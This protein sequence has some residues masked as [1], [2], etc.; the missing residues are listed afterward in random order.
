MRR[1]VVVAVAVLAGCSGGDAPDPP[2]DA[3][4][5]VAFSV[6]Q[7]RADENTPFANLRVINLDPDRSVEVTAIGLDWPG[8][9]EP[10]TRPE[11]ATVMAGQTLD[12]RMRLP[13]PVCDPSEPRPATAVAEIDGVRV[14]GPLQAAGRSLLRSLWSRS[15]TARAVAAVA[16]IRLGG[17]WHPVDGGAEPAYAGT[18]VVQRTPGSTARLVVVGVTGSIL[19][20]A[21]A[22]TP[23]VLGPEQRRLVIPVQLT[24]FR[25]DP[26]AR[27]ETTQAFLFRIDVVVGHQPSRR[28]TIT[29][30]DERWRAA[31]M[32]FLDSACR[33]S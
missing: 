9:G 13:D 22:A 2:P 21:A 18:L 17:S 7:Y 27:G 3:E 31:A 8:Y 15:C 24:P 23:A 19:F 5:R 33:D 30:H 4:P 20:E 14:T 11:A 26:H 16:D 10:F 29:S 1:A 28:V 25:C 32:D 6:S 12:L